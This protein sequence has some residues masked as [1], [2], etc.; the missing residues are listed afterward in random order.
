M[1]FGDFA[2]ELRRVEAEML[3]EPLRYVPNRLEVSPFPISGFNEETRRWIVLTEN[4]DG[5]PGPALQ[6][7]ESNLKI[8]HA[9]HSSLKSETQ[10]KEES[11][12]PKPNEPAS[13]SQ[14]E[15]PKEK[16]TP[17]KQNDGENS[18]D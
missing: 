6:M 13:G 11:S 16:S 14:E 8:I 10:S 4:P 9:L 15:E 5:T 12:S 2:E 3:A 18:E 7:K 1:S 17:S